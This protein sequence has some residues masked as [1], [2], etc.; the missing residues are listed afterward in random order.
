MSR[1]TEIM[2]VAI[3]QSTRCLRSVEGAAQAPPRLRDL[4]GADPRSQLD[5]IGEAGTVPKQALRLA[6]APALAVALERVLH[7]FFENAPGASELAQAVEVAE[8]R[9]VRIRRIAPAPRSARL[10]PGPFR[11]A[12]SASSTRRIAS[13]GLRPWAAT[14]T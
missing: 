9:H 10:A 6:E 3:A 2:L 11:R 4:V 13:L 5:H 1:P 12:M 14:P 7:F 8:H